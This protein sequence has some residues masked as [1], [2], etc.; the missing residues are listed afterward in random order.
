MSSYFKLNSNPEFLNEVAFG[1]VMKGIDT[2]NKLAP[3]PEPTIGN[4]IINISKD[5]KWTKTQRRTDNNFLEDNIPVLHLREYYVTQPGFITNVQNIFQ[6]AVNTLKNL[7][8][9]A[10]G[11]VAEG[12][13]V[14]NAANKVSEWGNFLTNPENTFGFDVNQA[15]QDANPMGK[16]LLSDTM[17]FLNKQNLISRGI[18]VE[19]YPYMKTYENMYGVTESKFKYIIPYFENDWKSISNKWQDIN[20][21]NVPGA[22]A[23]K[24]I[25]GVAQKISTGFG[26]DLAKTFDYPGEGPSSK[27][28]LILD[29]TYDSYFDDR[30]Y[31]SYQHNWEFIFLLLYQNLPNRR[32]K[33][34]FDPPVIYKAQVPG[35]FS[36]LYS[37]LSALS[38]ESVGNRQ[39]REIFINIQ[40]E[41]GRLE[42]K[43]FKT[44]I[45]EAFKI[46]LEL[47]SLLPETKNLF[48]HSFQD[49]ITT[50]TNSSANTTDVI[51]NSKSIFPQG[52]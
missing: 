18:S 35:V 27:L 8:G 21:D 37:Y 38:V 29:N 7:S 40:D 25:Q 44:L 3:L 2:G 11:Q 13:V 16:S 41:E 24:S 22:K 36:Y 23:F 20:M 52:L 12:S 15:I 10:A 14:D 46:N 5:F 34:F 6:T 51:K 30:R 49:K 1:D 4:G 42:L 19:G 32:N 39:P 9:F 17:G 28:T 50:R 26:V 47:K 33:L 43:T 31:N 45:P 48:L